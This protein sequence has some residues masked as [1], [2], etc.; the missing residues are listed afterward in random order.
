MSLNWMLIILNNSEHFINIFMFFH[1]EFLFTA[2]FFFHCIKIFSSFFLQ[3][4]A[5]IICLRHWRNTFYSDTF[6]NWKV[7]KILLL[8]LL[9]FIFDFFICFSCVDDMCNILTNFT[10]V[11]IVSIFNYLIARHYGWWVPHTNA[12]IKPSKTITSKLRTLN[13]LVLHFWRFFCEPSL[14]SIY[15]GF[16][17]I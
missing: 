1:S 13:D 17:L 14:F 12:N 3:K 15:N 9:P 2:F 7:K 8:P 6:E 16:T 5:D 4:A 11:I 10:I